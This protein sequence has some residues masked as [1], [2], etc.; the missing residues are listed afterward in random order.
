MT[1]TS[2]AKRCGASRQGRS[3]RTKGLCCQRR[4]RRPV[5]P[6]E[7]AHRSC[8]P[9][10]CGSASILRHALAARAL[11]DEISAAA[12]QDGTVHGLPGQ[13]RLEAPFGTLDLQPLASQIYGLTG[14]VYFTPIFGG[15]LADRVLGQRATVIIG[16][17]PHG[18]RPFPMMAV[19]SAASSRRCFDPGP[20]RLA[21]FT[22]NIHIAGRR[23][24]T[25]RAIT[26]A[27]PPISVFYVGINLGAFLSPRDL[28]HAR[29][30]DRLAL[31]LCRRRSSACASGSASVST[32]PMLAARQACSRPTGRRSPARIRGNGPASP[33]PTGGR[34]I[35]TLL[36]IC[37]A[38][39]TLFLGLPTS[40]KGIR[41]AS[42]A[43]ANTD[44]A[45]HR[46]FWR[47]ADIPA[48][49]FQAFNPFMIFAFTPFVVAL[50]SRR[51]CGRARHASRRAIT[52]M[53]LR[54]SLGVTGDRQS[55]SWRSAAAWRLVNRQGQL[56]LAVRLLRRSS[57]SASLY[58]VAHRPLAGHQGRAGSGSLSTMMACGWRFPPCRRRL[59]CPGWLGSRAGAA[60][61][62][63]PRFFLMI[64]AIAA[65]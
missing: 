12:D 42:W 11:H 53:A 2:P 65:R 8:S 45:V 31:R 51:Q 57:P 35:V 1:G 64:A 49:W 18:G 40:S 58:L 19:E 47:A 13:V 52:K 50:W 21:L 46:L 15:L 7:R 62:R 54:L 63:G 36:L 56:V 20:R 32:L 29:R 26:G 44:R 39:S 23:A 59:S 22:P 41:V 34:C 28:R 5:R 55:S 30:G 3:R 17:E 6:S 25:R 9:P 27:T 14:L 33:A 60:I 16:V 38:P 24:S 61:G 37:I 4:Q 43:D 10:K 48:T